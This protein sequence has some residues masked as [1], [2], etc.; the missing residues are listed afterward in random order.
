MKFLIA[1]LA[2]AGCA[3]LPADPSKMSPEQIK[4]WVRDKNASIS[5]GKVNTP[6]GPTVLTYVTLDK[7]VI[8]EGVVTVDAEC[9]VSITNDSRKVKP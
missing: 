8:F 9:K 5:C 7:S 2:L 3:Q 6:Y 1:L 4:E